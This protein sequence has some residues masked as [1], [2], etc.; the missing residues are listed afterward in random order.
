MKK[1]KELIKKLYSLQIKNWGIPTSEYDS[2]TQEEK[3]ML[4]P[5]E[6]KYSLKSQFKNQIKV[7]AN[8]S[9]WPPLH[10]H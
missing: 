9:H 8:Y 5:K 6:G 1:L 10:S 2:L 7:V 3:Q 4:E